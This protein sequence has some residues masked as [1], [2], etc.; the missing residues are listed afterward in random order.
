MGNL[1]SNT[2]IACNV[3]VL[4]GVVGLLSSSMLF[5]F[6][7]Y[8]DAVKTHELREDVRNVATSIEQNIAVEGNNGF[9]MPVS[10]LPNVDYR[11]NDINTTI[12]LAGNSRN[13]YCVIAT[14]PEIKSRTE[15]I[16]YSSTDIAS[17][18]TGKDV[19]DIDTSNAVTAL[20]G[21]PMEEHFN[22]LNY[23]ETTGMASLGVTG[24][25]IL[26][27]LVN[28]FIPRKRRNEVSDEAQLDEAPLP[29][30]I[31]SSDSSKPVDSG[32][33]LFALREK[34]K[35]IKSEW[36]SYEMDLVKLLEYPS[37]TDLSVP[38]TA[39]F[40][41]SLKNVNYL[42]SLNKTQAS[43]K[44]DTFRQSVLDLEHNFDVMI[45]VAKRTKWN[46]YSKKEQDSL[47]TAQ[48]LLAIAI[49][50]ASSMNERQIAYKRLIKEV[51]GILVFPEKAILELEAKVSPAITV[52]DLLPAN[53]K[54]N[55]PFFAKR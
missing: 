2:G 22:V 21:E 20:E 25:S 51:E 7:E 53:E 40:H 30:T 6:S 15:G 45:S 18:S 23:S 11:V 24:L 10:S 17:E 52:A 46:G 32:N 50:S 5:G 54:A 28:T 43:D 4:A 9:D 29:K 19:C 41:K 14:N 12:K 55:V 3:G 1:Q 47:R 13:G 31:E 8:A 16:Q 35:R 39:E 42:D 26:T 38:A 27:G 36:T 49:N 44:T 33:E 37:V 34:V 48:N